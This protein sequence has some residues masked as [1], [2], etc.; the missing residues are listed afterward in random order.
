[1]AVIAKT[2]R[3]VEHDDRDADP[4]S[5]PEIPKGTRVVYFEG[6]CTADNR[7]LAVVLGPN[8]STYRI[9]PDAIEIVDPWGELC[10]YWRCDPR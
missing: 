1:M 7:D 8:G 3:T 9:D 6:V 10:D 5:Y 2:L 4:K